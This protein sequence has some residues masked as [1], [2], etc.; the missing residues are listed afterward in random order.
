MQKHLKSPYLTKAQEQYSRCTERVLTTPPCAFCVCPSQLY[1]ALLLFLNRGGGGGG[2]RLHV[3]L[4]AR[5][6]KH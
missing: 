2:R 1:I 5:H 6:G 4:Q 3:A